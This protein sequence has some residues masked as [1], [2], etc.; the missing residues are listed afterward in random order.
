[1]EELGRMRH[2]LRETLQIGD[3]AEG[4]NEHSRL[5]GGLPEFDSV[6]I[7]SV[8]MAIEQEYGVK[9]PDR[10]LSADIFETLGSLIRF[11]SHKVDS[12]THN[13]STGA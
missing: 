5:L 11:I 3:K 6:A 13:K 12:T 2:L 1:M 9:I 7:V 4:L 8:V 10:E